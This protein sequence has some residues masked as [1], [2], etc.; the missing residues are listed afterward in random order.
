MTLSTITPE[1]LNR[2][3]REVTERLED[4]K[5]IGPL[6]DSARADTPIIEMII[7]VLASL[8]QAEPQPGRGEALR[9]VRRDLKIFLALRDIEQSGVPYTLT[10]HS[11]TWYNAVLASFTER[12][13]Q[14]TLAS[15][16]V[17]CRHYRLIFRIL[18]P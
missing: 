6:L 16:Y 2:S 7:G 5:S 11:M 17:G 3:L 10:G 4:E 15:P 13:P 9:A 1:E 14:T 8:L 12:K 18:N